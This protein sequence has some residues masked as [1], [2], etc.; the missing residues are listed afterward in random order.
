M[1]FATSITKCYA[2]VGN[3]SILKGMHVSKVR[4]RRERGGSKLRLP[5]QQSK[6]Y[7]PEEVH[8]S[9]GHVRNINTIL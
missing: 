5:S 6:K 8:A 9:F 3:I 2:T 1:Y 4:K 7:I